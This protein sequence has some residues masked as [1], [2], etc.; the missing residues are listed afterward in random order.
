MLKSCVYNLVYNPKW[1]YKLRWVA[2][3][4]VYDGLE[5]SFLRENNSSSGDLIADKN[6]ILIEHKK[7]EMSYTSYTSPV[8]RLAEPNEEASEDG[9]SS[10]NYHISDTYH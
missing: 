4:T 9:N 3:Y 5:K 10:E 8:E 2:M 7:E 6:K 1:H